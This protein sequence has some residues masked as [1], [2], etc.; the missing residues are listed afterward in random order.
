MI[1]LSKTNLSKQIGERLPAE[2]VDFMR[3]AGETARRRGW[4]LYLVGGVVRDLLLTRTNLDLDM[5]VEGDAIELATELA[6]IKVGKVTSHRAFNTATIKWEHWSVDLATARSE[7]YDKPGALPKIKPDSIAVD[8]FRRD[9]TIN[10]MAVRLAPSQYG[11]LIDIYGGRVDLQNKLIRILHDKSF[12]DDATRIWRAVRYEHRLGFHLEPFTRRLLKRDID[13]LDTISGDRIRHELE[14]A[15]KEDK[16]EKVL[17]RADELGVLA[18]LH[19]PLKADKWLAEKFKQARRS[20]RPEPAP[21]GLYLALLVYRL[22]DKELEQTISY[23]RLPKQLAEG[24]KDTIELKENLPLLDNRKL[25]P[26]RIYNVLQ[27]YSSL[28]ITANMLAVDS[29]VVREHIEL[30]LNKL[31]YIK[32]ALTGEDLLKMGMPAG[33]RLKEIL[34]LLLEARLDGKL[35]TRKDEEELVKTTLSS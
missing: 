15:L 33:P 5:V 23:L 1:Y 34:Q 10:A 27:S 19:P 24:L 17:R 16:P 31:R 21:W 3:L 18:K 20:T 35:A 13:Y 8:L 11:R 25:K 9:F 26:S 12:I 30:Y 14:L 7:T 2:L 22:T 4:K 32:S 6:R 28:A 29:P